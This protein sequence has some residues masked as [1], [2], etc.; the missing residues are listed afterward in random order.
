MSNLHRHKTVSDLSTQN[1]SDNQE[2]VD[3]SVPSPDISD[4]HIFMI[5]K[6]ISHSLQS[7]FKGLETTI[8]NLS[9]DIHRLS[10]ASSSEHA[11]QADDG[12]SPQSIAYLSSKH[13]NSQTDD[14]IFTYT[15]KSA[16]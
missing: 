10:S 15:P 13:A 7:S 3:L 4:P 14:R 11:L 5:T 12:N 8:G 9:K 6:A 2:N 1:G 16:R